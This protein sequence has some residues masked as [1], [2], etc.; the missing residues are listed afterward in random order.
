MLKQALALTCKAARSPVTW[1]P[2]VENA[3]RFST[4]HGF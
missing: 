2:L 1:P 3:P 4:L